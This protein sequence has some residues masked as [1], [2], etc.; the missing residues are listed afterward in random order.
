MM[1]LLVLVNMYSNG[2]CRNLMSCESL[3]ADYMSCA[4]ASQSVDSRASRSAGIFNNGSFPLAS[5]I[6]YELFHW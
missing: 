4:T 3:I 1:S 2:W 6:C 5:T